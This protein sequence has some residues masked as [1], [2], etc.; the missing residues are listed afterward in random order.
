MKKW[1]EEHMWIWPLFG[2][3]FLWVVIVAVTGKFSLM[4][5]FSSA[6]LASFTLLLALAQMVVITSGN[7][8][9]DLSTTYVFTLAAYISTSL[10][11]INIVLGIVV[12]VAA[13]V[14]IGIINGT[15]NIYLKV[16]A[17]ITTLATGYITFT[18]IL[19][20]APYMKTLPNKAFVKFIVKNFGGFSV[21]TILC[22]VIAILLG[23]LLYRTKYGK[24]LHAVGQN[25]IAAKFAGISVP[26]TIIKTFALSGGISAI[27]GVFCGAF[28]GGAFQDM[29]IAYFLPSVAATL[30]GGTIASGGK[31]SVAGAV[32]GALM[33]SLMTSLLNVAHLS[34]GY[35]KLIQGAVLVL[36]LVA[37][38]SKKKK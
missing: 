36:I 10:M 11:N 28:I 34:P 27:A 14:L 17:M 15:I 25:R 8:A 31:S 33:M 5:L 23:I 38:I 7:G 16:P 32:L 22:I 18:V 9:I 30:I 26:K 20:S 2:S 13:G 29:G 3:V 4:Q 19:I 37:S 24:Q 6:T 21:L 12:A 1:M 35:Q